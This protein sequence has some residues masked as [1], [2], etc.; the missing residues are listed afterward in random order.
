MIIREPKIP[1][2]VPGVHPD[3]VRRVNRQLFGMLRRDVQHRV[4]EANAAHRQ[5]DLG[6]HGVSIRDFA[7]LGDVATEDQGEDKSG[8]S[9][10][11]G[12]GEGI[13]QRDGIDEE[14]VEAPEK[15]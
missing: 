8:M 10:I 9:V 11:E 7:P 15:P 2:D 5:G 12:Q 3:R 6:R 14:A 13:K 1:E 4:D